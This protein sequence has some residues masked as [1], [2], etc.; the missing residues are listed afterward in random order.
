MTVYSFLQKN[1]KAF[2]RGALFAVVF[3][4]S[5][6]LSQKPVAAQNVF[7]PEFECLFTSSTTT[8]CDHS[9]SNI[10]IKSGTK[11]GIVY[12]KIPSG[13]EYIDT[14]GVK[15][16]TMILGLAMDISKINTMGT[17]DPEYSNRN[18]YFWSRVADD[19]DDTFVVRLGYTKPGTTTPTYKLQTISAKKESV[20]FSTPLGIPASVTLALKLPFTIN[21]TKNTVGQQEK[22]AFFTKGGD[23]A[24]NSQVVQVVM[25]SPGNVSIP[26]GSTM[27]ADLWYCAGLQDYAPN[28]DGRYTPRTPTTIPG[29]QRVEYFTTDGVYTYKDGNGNA[30]KATDG[31]K[32]DEEKCGGTAHYKI[33]NTVTFSLPKDVTAAQSDQT[34]TIDTGIK[35]SENINPGDNLPG[36]G[37]WEGSIIGCVAQVVYYLVFNPI[38]WVAGIIGRAFD[39]FLGYS[40]S[41]ESYRA[42]VIVT[43]WKLVRDI[44]NIFFILILVWTGLST[45]FGFSKVSMRS[46]VPQLIINALLINF[47]LFGARVVIDI[48]NVTARLFYNTMSVCQGTCDY[49]VDDVTGKKI[50]TNPNTE[51][52]A[53]FKPLSAKI[54]SAFDP[55]KIFNPKILSPDNT[56]NTTN[57]T[58]QGSADLQRGVSSDLNSNEY[59][60]YF[61]IVT[62]IAAFIMFGIAKMFFGVMFMFVGRVVGLYMV[63]IFA[64]FAIMT[65]GGM[66]LVGDMK[67]IGWK[68]WSSDLVKYSV[69]APV[70]VFFL[71]IIYSFINSDFVQAMNLDKEAGFMGTV[72]GIVI[73]M[74]IIYMLVQQG[75]KIAEKYAG[76]AGEM[77]QKFGTSAT[78]MVAGTAL[79]IATGGLGLVGRGATSILGKTA[80]TWAATNKDTNLLAGGVNKFLKWGQK[81]SFDVRNTAAGGTLTSGVG[82]LLGGTK[83]FSSKIKLGQ[84]DYIGGNAKIVKDREKRVEEKATKKNDMSHLTDAQAAKAW[85]K[86]AEKAAQQNTEK[87]WKKA[88]LDELKKAE[89][90]LQVL[91]SKAA[92]LEKDLE[93]A[94]TAGDMTNQKIIGD[95][96]AENKKNQASIISLLNT[97]VF[98]EKKN[99]D[100][101]NSDLYKD[102]LKN[103]K[104]KIKQKY[105]DVK[106]A[107]ELSTAMRYEYAQRMLENS[108]YLAD[109]KKR[110]RVAPLSGGGVGSAGMLTI[111]GIAGLTGGIAGGGLFGNYIDSLQEAEKNVFSKITKDYEKAHS[112]K[113]NK[114]LALQSKIEEI[115]KFVD[116]HIEKVLDGTGLTMDDIKKDEKLREEHFERARGRAD[117]EFQDAEEEYNK[118][119][120]AYKTN[121]T[122]DTTAR[123]EEESRNYQKKKDAFNDLNN[124]NKNRETA[125]NNLDKEKDRVKEKEDKDKNKPGDKKE[126]EKPKDGK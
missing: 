69:L 2:F 48:S 81:S 19:P 77:F 63:M 107:K 73:P 78:G 12:G 117:R 89:A 99:A 112:K 84:K 67:E 94:K 95:Q 90:P 106:N 122:P 46:I 56:S 109:G 41:D 22:I 9:A 108:A 16:V 62:L 38:Q 7:Y 42:E 24:I 13:T 5:L 71:Y 52:T 91:E 31:Y 105:G 92:L 59:A 96:I 15:A 35:A 17:N 85:E 68:D 23:H 4:S 14:T 55:Q 8:P 64:P 115:D 50:L 34:T 86:R 118:A 110:W 72:L 6:L 74:F 79:G 51:T 28:H 100:Y 70:F 47:S 36:C 111:G 66:P 126:P 124:A 93:T 58:Q 83:D 116:S 119:K 98:D 29:D 37:V 30:V 32:Y 21:T 97:K 123:F 60:G 114:L 121:K 27:T 10:D 82:K 49:K 87:S 120:N 102:S 20:S 26:Y 101:K 65:R 57:N 125:Q 53:G 25:D 43:G 76:K 113:D 88:R 33:G 103:E 3:F 11:S 54:V 44:S 80:G 61:L 18:N 40:I 104:A 45:V 39:F 75:V 1:Q